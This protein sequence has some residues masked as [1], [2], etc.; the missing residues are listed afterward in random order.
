MSNTIYLESGLNY[1]SE[2]EFENLYNDLDKVG[3]ILEA[4][5]ESEAVIKHSLW[6]DVAIYINEN[7]TALIISGVIVPATYDVIKASLKLIINSIKEKV[8]IVQNGEVKNSQPYIRF[9]TEKGE[10][11]ALIPEDISDYQY[12]KYMDNVKEAINA[13]SIDESDN[14]IDNSIVLEASANMEIKPRK[15]TEYIKERKNK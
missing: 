2:D 15:L 12:D 10:L 5:K 9:K 4:T 14:I 6:S 11:F 1:L 3:I 13:L 7:L 8:K